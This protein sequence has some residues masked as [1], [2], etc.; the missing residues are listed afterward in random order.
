MLYDYMLRPAGEQKFM[1]EEYV[2]SPPAAWIY[3]E[4]GDVFTLGTDRLLFQA[5]APNGE[6]AFLVQRNGTPVGIFAS[7][8]ERRNGKIRAFTRQG[9]LIW[10][11][12]AFV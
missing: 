5:D 2:S 4:R 6:F 9:W 1:T 10:N 3:D 7:R 8:L 12:N 11:G